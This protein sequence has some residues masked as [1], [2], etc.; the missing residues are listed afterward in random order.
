[1]EKLPI[2]GVIG[3]TIA[4]EAANLWTLFRLTWFPLALLLAA[5][6]GLTYMLLQEVGTVPFASVDGV[7]AFFWL[8]WTSVIL[9]TIAVTAVAV[10]VHKVVLFNERREGHYFVYPFGWTEVRYIIMGI[11]SSIFIILPV[12]IAAY[13]YYAY[14]LNVSQAAIVALL[15]APSVP[16]AP[17]GASWINLVVIAL[18]IIFVLWVSLR[19]S[20]W[21]A[22]VV[23][24]NRIALVDAWR[25]TRGNVLR[26]LLMFILAYIFLIVVL[27]LIQGAFFFA[28]PH[29]FLQPVPAANPQIK[30]ALGEMANVTPNMLLMEFITQFLSTTFAVAL[31]SFSYRALKG[32]RDGTAI[33]KQST[34]DDPTLHMPMGAL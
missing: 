19:L 27:L 17:Q 15:A 25:T 18:V 2:F 34:E 3:R 30:D 1:M 4:F 33:D 22:A 21:P 20:V 32:A 8:I 6:V 28:A 14:K 24:N 16:L 7:Y 5:S 23:A 13:V 31:L 26:L 12:A 9:Q 10:Q 29:D 11:L